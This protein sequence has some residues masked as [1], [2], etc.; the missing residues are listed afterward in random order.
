MLCILFVCCVEF[1]GFG[2]GFF[3]VCFIYEVVLIVY[4]LVV[5][6]VMVDMFVDG[7]VLIGG[8]LCWFDGL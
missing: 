6:S 2:C 3:M 7:V 4:D 8:M 1:C 5:N